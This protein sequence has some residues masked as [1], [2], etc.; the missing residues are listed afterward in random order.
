MNI[1]SSEQTL[2]LSMSSLVTV[3]AFPF[4]ASIQHLKSHVRVPGVHVESTLNSFS[5]DKYEIRG[6]FFFN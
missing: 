1:S 4:S 2:Q 6:F 5:C 3:S